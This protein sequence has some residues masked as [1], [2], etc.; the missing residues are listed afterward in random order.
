[1]EL[2]ADGYIDGRGRLQ[3]SADQKPILLERIAKHAGKN[4]T[5]V[6]D[7]TGKKRSA[8]QNRY[9]YG[10]VIPMVQDAI[11]NE[12]QEQYTKEEIHELLK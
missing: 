6:I 10:V 2:K 1:M 11:Q 3:I 9:Y 4:V 7:I 5:L 8:E 12:W